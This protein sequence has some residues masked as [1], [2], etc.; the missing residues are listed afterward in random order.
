VI[1]LYKLEGRTLNDVAE[2]MMR[3]KGATCRLIARAME[4]LRSLLPDE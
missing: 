3:S 4:K 1:T 2:H